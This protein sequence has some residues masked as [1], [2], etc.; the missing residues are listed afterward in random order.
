MTW[1]F[2]LVL[3]WSKGFAVSCAEP[4][5][6]PTKGVLEKVLYFNGKCFMTNGHKIPKERRPIFNGCISP[7][8]L[9]QGERFHRGKGMCCVIHL[10]QPCD[11]LETTSSVIRIPPLPHLE[12]STL[13]SWEDF[14]TILQAQ[15]L[16]E[17]L[18]LSGSLKLTKTIEREPLV[19]MAWRQ[20]A[21]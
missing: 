17:P 12:K 19:V 14:A 20:Q 3:K 5:H 13:Y 21:V 9:T 10:K 16:K 11:G 2:K 15:E 18:H 7:F 8:A 6:T 1:G 4:I